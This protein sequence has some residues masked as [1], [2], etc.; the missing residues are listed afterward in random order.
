MKVYLL[1]HHRDLPALAVNVQKEAE[2]PKTFGSE[3]PLHNYFSFYA[4]QPTA[5]EKV[6]LANLGAEYITLSR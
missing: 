5:H 2:K 1:Q 3:L 4:K 6:Q